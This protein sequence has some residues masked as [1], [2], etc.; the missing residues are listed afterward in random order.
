MY[1]VKCNYTRLASF[2][3]PG[4]K[5]LLLLLLLSSQSLSI[6]T[7]GR[8]SV[9]TSRA[10]YAGARYNILKNMSHVRRGGHDMILSKRWWWPVRHNIPPRR[11]A[12]IIILHIIII[13][14]RRLHTHIQIHIVTH[15]HVHK[16][17]RN[18]K[19][20]HTHTRNHALAYTHT[21]T[22]IHT[23]TPP[24]QDNERTRCIISRTRVD[25]QTRRRRCRRPAHERCV[26]VVV[27][28]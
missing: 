11:R 19:H 3:T 15:A 14:T 7:E 13:G 5:P 9:P 1:V 17:I 8:A 22:H 6:G 12:S 26:L 23:P 4:R 10:S 21:H 28:L 20:T 24:P 16:Y 25:R 27:L 18:P 2:N